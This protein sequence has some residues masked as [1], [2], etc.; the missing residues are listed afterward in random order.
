MPASSDR[1][2]RFA[3][4]EAALAEYLARA[5]AG[6]PLEFEPWLAGHPAIERELRELHA[7]CG[8]LRQ[9]QPDAHEGGA[10]L[11]LE[12]LDALGRAPNRF[13]EYAVEPTPLAQGGMGTIFSA[14][15]RALRRELVLKILRRGGGRGAEARRFA[16]FLTEARVTSQLGHPGIVPVYEIGLDAQQ[17]PYF[18]MKRVEGR[19]LESAFDSLAAGDPNWTQAR[20]LG[21]LQRVCEA[22]SFAHAKGVIHRDLKPANV[23]VGEFGE[24]YVMDWGLAR[25][26]GRRDAHDLRLQTGANAPGQELG[27]SPLVTLDGSV[28]GT[29]AYMPPEQA[30]GEIEK[31]TTRSDVYSIGAL[32]YHLLAGERPYV[33]PGARATARSV[34]LQVLAGP[35][36]PL[37]ELRRD[38]PA[39]LVAICEKA[40]ARDPAQRYAD[41]LA[42]SEDLRA[43]LENRVV[44]AYQ[45][46]A[47]AE[48]RKWVARNRALALASAAA[49]L[50]ALCG[51]A[52]VS[53]VQT[54]ARRAIGRTLQD[55][56]AIALADASKA[57]ETVDPLRALLLA[58]E[59]AH[60]QLSTDVESQLHSAL[61]GSL[62]DALFR[63]HP[64]RFSPA[65]FSPSGD[66]VLYASGAR[67]ARISELEGSASV[68]LS[69]DDRSL[70]AAAFAPDGLHVVTGAEDGTLRLWDRATL[71][72]RRLEGHTDF[73]LAV[74]C[75]SRGRIASSSLDGSVRVWEADGTAL[76][77]FHG[78][79]GRI[80]ALAW[81]PDGERL[82]SAAQDG[83]VYV[84]R[85]DG[86]APEHLRHYA[87][88]LA[89][90]IS[91]EGR[92]LSGTED[93]F[94][95][96]W[97][98]STP[99]SAQ[100]FAEHSAVTSVA[101][102]HDGRQFAIGRRNG[103]ARVL[104]S[105]GEQVA[106]LRGHTSAVCSIAF[107]PDDQLLATAGGE[108][109]TGRVWDQ[110]GR[111]VCVLRGHTGSV[112][113]VQFA[114]DFT[115]DRGRLLSS[116]TDGTARTWHLKGAEIATYR[117]V[118]FGARAVAVSGVGRRQA[119]I[120]GAT[121]PA[122]LQGGVRPH[123]YGPANEALHSAKF[124]RDA[125]RVLVAGESGV[126]RVFELDETPLA[127]IQT[128][129]P[130]CLADFSPQD[131]NL[132][133]VW[134][135]AT[136][137]LWELREHRPRLVRSFAGHEDR[138]L[139]AAFSQNGRKIVTGSRDR[140]ARVFDVDSGVCEVTFVG[141]L[142][143][144][145]SA[146][147][148]SDGRRVLTA[149][150]QTARI[151]DLATGRGR[152]LLHTSAAEV[153]VFSP[154]DELVGV[155]CSDGTAWLWETETARLRAQ[156]PGHSAGV[157]SAE[158][159][160]DES[161]S[162]LYLA[163]ACAD[164]NVRI[165]CTTAGGVLAIVE[166]KTLGRRFTH[167][168]IEQYSAILGH[169]YDALLAAYQFIEPRLAQE[170]VV[171]DVAADVEAEAQL[172]ADVR[173]EAL[174][175]LQ[176]LCDDPRHVCERTWECVRTNGLAGEQYAR[177]LRWARTADELAHGDL[178]VRLVLG[179]ALH[180]VGHEAEALRTLQAI[181]ARFGAR[182]REQ[183][184]LC[185]AALALVQHALGNDESA[186]A[187]LAR[188]PDPSAEPAPRPERAF[189]AEALAL[190]APR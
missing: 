6:E 36:R 115:P 58:K 70:S 106:E 114:P 26:L 65:L 180:R 21:V 12:A 32:L 30:R 5:A 60:V 117:S 119:L 48:F 71:R 19:T 40:M 162:S 135:G 109:R 128:H 107:S 77:E 145:V 173:L 24:V 167:A 92:I 49:I 96:I 155:G 75:S 17:Q 52:W 157:I 182:D 29:P 16:R 55:A 82:A 179:V 83:D 99:R 163:T 61:V 158:F 56:R 183:Q 137:Q 64:G 11:M 111:V 147:F 62:E 161:A 53:L 87:P 153:A 59:A 146:L 159:E 110:K 68:E 124:S 112:N 152:P 138:V 63:G 186:R 84:W 4:A 127:E 81:L 116:S 79:T 22:V 174:G 160:W 90:A 18:A 140:L 105:G 34:L 171:A 133:L 14:R 136:A 149:G 103:T 104:L 27:D 189:F 37:H 46:G 118:E 44:R 39:E 3:Q 187:E 113:C 129:D 176:G 165:R 50:I 95:W 168:E 102:S 190:R 132:I 101:F 88:V 86:G 7:V 35:P 20:A 42:L 73:V 25:E 66:S 9:P 28:V 125:Q 134:A 126:V 184:E 54:S 108:D 151:W 100:L 143:P 172:P 8:V 80:T 121:G 98:V 94:A 91:P 67:G 10:E 97:E 31:L 85:L 78:H 43:F 89:L 156:L 148:S 185:T 1:D 76:G 13:G 142:G 122:R 139:C 141:H 169:D 38:I 154:S 131:S 2:R 170:V 120:V 47:L 57:A 15:D 23:M 41:T 72:N 51:L 188:L 33:Q 150:D 69:S 175:V 178:G 93:G 45:T 177:A 164:G 166:R 130:E 123:T 74:A 144:V 181:D